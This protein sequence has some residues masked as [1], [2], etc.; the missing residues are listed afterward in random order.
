[1]IPF[2][3]LESDDFDYFNLVGGRPTSPDV[4]RSSEARRIPRTARE[5]GAGSEHS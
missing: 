4:A 1:M 2:E 3:K 5:D